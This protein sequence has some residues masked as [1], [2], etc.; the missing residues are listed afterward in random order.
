MDLFLVGFVGMSQLLLGGLGI[1]VSLRPPK[2]EHHRYWIG[3]F[4]FIGILGIGLTIWQAKR[5]A[6]AQAA[7]QLQLQLTELPKKIPRPPTAQEN[8]AAIVALQKQEA[9]LAKGQS[10][11]NSPPSVHTNLGRG[12][13]IPPQKPPQ[14][15]PNNPITTQLIVT[16]S[17]DIS[18]R[19]ETPYKTRVVVQSTVEFSSLRLAIEC[20]GPIAQGSGGN[21]AMFMTN[22]GIVDG[23]P[24]IYVLTYQSATPPLGP[25][26][27]L[28][29]IFCSKGPINCTHASTF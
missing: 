20:D 7:L 8:A 22:Q 12:N 18:D 25:A 11:K 27:P 28:P 4:V 17:L 14:Q 24:N 16:Q 6:D 15:A 10:P 19:P 1:Y 23:H 2:A 3:C 9:S 29:F 5:G 13:K 26:N 21:G